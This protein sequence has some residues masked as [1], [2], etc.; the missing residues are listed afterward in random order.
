LLI[1]SSSSIYIAEANSLGAPTERIGTTE[2]LVS[3]ILTEVNRFGELHQKM[4]GV[5]QYLF[6]FTEKC[7]R[8]RKDRLT[9]PRANAEW[10]TMGALFVSHSSSDQAATK[11][12]VER[13]NGEGFVA[14]FL[15]FHSVHGI[16]AGGVWESELYAQLRKADGVIFLA[17]A[18]SV[19]TQW[20]FAEISLAR[21]LHKPVFPLRLEAGVRL[22]LLDDVQ[23]IDLSEGETAFVKLWAGLRRA[24]LDPT[25]SFAWDPARSPYPGLE[26]FTGDDAAVF[27]GRDDE[28]A[29]LV[30]L[31]QPTLQRGAG[32]FVAVVGPSGS[33][34]SSLVRAGLLPRLERLDSRW[35]VLPALVP[36][37]HPTRNL[38]HCL[39]AAFAGRGEPRPLEEITAALGRGGAG[40]V[41]LA[42][43]LGQLAGATVHGGPASG[44]VNVLVVIDQAEELLTRTGVSEQQAF[45]GLL[46]N[47]LGA[48]S[49]VWAVATVRS[50]FLSTAPER[51]GL[52]EVIDDPLVIEPLS[53]AR[54]PIVIQQPAERAGLQFAAGLVEQMVEETTGGDALPL[55]AYML[56]ELYQ[57]AGPDGSVTIT[58]YQELGGVVGALQRRA[59]RLTE[60][61]GRRRGDESVLP[62][63]TKFAVVEGDAEPT[64]RR[65]PRSALGP[66]EQVVADAF[67]EARLLTSGVDADGEAVVGVAHEALLRQWP[68]LREAIEASRA[69]LRMRS[70]LERLAA[71]WDLG[72]RDDSY[73][74]R[75]A[76]LSTFN[77]WAA[78][79][80][81][82]LGPLERQFIETAKALASK[83]LEATRRSNRR[84]R[85]L[86]LSLMVLVVAIGLVAFIAIRASQNANQQRDIAVSRQ[87]IRESEDLGSV[88]PET[89]RLKSLAAWRIHPSPDTRQ[90]M[91][92]AASLPG[93]AVL[94]GHTDEVYSVAFS[95]DGKT[96][97]SGSNDHS[98]RLWDVAS[99]R[100]IG[101][102]LTG[103]TGQVHSV[104]FS[105][106]GKTLATGSWDHS[107]R[108]WDVASHRQLGLPLTGHTNWV[109]SVAF[110]P[111]G[112]TLASGSADHSVRLWDVASHRQIGSPL[113]GHT[114]W[115]VSVAF[116]PDGKTLASGS[117]D[118]SVRLWDVAKHRQL[119]SPLTGHTDIVEWVVFSPG[120]KTL[121]SGSDDHSV[122]LWN[123]ASHRQVGS[124]LISR[125]SAVY[126]VAF[127]RDGKTLASGGL[128]QSVRLWDVASHRQLGLPLTGHTEAVS[129]V[130]FSPDDKTLASGSNDHSVRLWDVA[131]H[132]QLGPPLTGHTEAVSSVAFGPDGTTVASGSDD[133][134]VRLWDV[135]SHRQLGPPLTGHTDEINSVAFS[136]DGK[137]LASGSADKSV[138]LWDVASHRQLGPPLTGHTNEV[139]SVTFSPDGKTLATASADASARLWDVDS[140]RQIGSPLAGHT[141]EVKSV[142]FS[143]DGKTVASGSADDS[144]RLWDIASH[145]Q[146]GSP[147]TGHTDDVESVAFSPDGK[148]VVSGSV[149]TSVRVWDVAS[150][151]QVGS[152]LTGHT[153]EVASVAFSPDRKTVVSGS[154]DTSI[155]LWNVPQLG[156][157]ASFLCKSLGQSPTREQWQNLVPEGPKYRELCP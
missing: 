35:V 98:V 78:G 142:A 76:R 81:S 119:G 11:Q 60:E 59:D 113:T 141:D 102:P 47:A 144:V 41:E 148:A 75:G 39:A 149:D 64:S 53:R 44:R 38:A 34:K 80:T 71:D 7:G 109:Y 145:G 120:G 27:F 28:I 55:L 67:V 36:D 5:T 85:T 91:L 105:P 63:L 61:L 87:L 74:L 134:S 40:L 19:E 77:E 46:R 57:Q 22:D 96:L 104:V 151:R 9:R 112:K 127:S 92:A 100:Q 62:T 72:G 10:T 48:G 118:H 8:M 24:G 128:D 4:R 106:D 135:A 130:T 18:A 6:V 73:L 89:A 17:S 65:I 14:L 126:S 95:A 99:H 121:A 49:P 115:V 20:C 108:L 137:T 33:G 3:L 70:E 56:R 30:E 147:L 43:E 16:P 117:A 15:D 139:N 93:L 107:L 66:D 155:R 124:S 45:L 2:A 122:R 12:V 94:T 88:N 50:E 82:E 116:S 111:D 13:L 54:L 152:P 123:V 51:A 125:N 31:L 32:R 79:D 114:D 84:L 150:H 154:A 86:A 156:D 21:S 26:S 153:D 90:A 68:P 83:Q 29:R 138:R 69:S 157:A 143:P 132:R 52:A 58:E 146:V 103:H 129:S 131:S 23:W 97:A 133:H 101:S 140:H 25:N 37:Q 136:P 1:N 42:V 110:S